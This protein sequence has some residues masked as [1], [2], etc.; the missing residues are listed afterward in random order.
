MA[1][2]DDAPNIVFGEQPSAAKISH[3]YRTI[4]QGAQPAGAQPPGQKGIDEEIVRR[5]RLDNDD[6]EQN[7]ALKR[8]V[9]DRLFWFLG[10]ETFA[11][12]LCTLLQA[13]GWFGFQLDEW[14]FNILVTATIAQIASMLLVAVRYLFPTKKDS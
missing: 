4:A 6:I 8:V 12:F 10:I 5:Q 2:K 3:I 11:I 14:S 7:I 1:K 9:L 13:T